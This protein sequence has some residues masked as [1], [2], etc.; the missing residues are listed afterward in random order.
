MWWTILE[1]V[2]AILGLVTA[3]TLWNQFQEKRRPL[4]LGCLLIG[5]IILSIHSHFETTKS[6]ETIEKLR[7]QL[8]TA[9]QKIVENDMVRKKVIEY[10]DMAKLNAD[11]ST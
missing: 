1:I 5:I 10:G 11:G 6:E 3:T 2:L 4:L 7:V 9:E 8:D